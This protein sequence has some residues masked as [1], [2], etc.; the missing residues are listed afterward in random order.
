[1]KKILIILSLLFI[2][3]STSQSREEDYIGWDVSD[4]LKK[5][6][7][8]IKQEQ[9][10]YQ[11]LVFLTNNRDYVVCRVSSSSTWCQKK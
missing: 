7:K 9:K 3:V 4:L 10:D 8:I 5:G 11:T 1:M 6:F 2:F